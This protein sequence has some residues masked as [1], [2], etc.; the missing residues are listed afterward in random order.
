MR[1]VLAESENYVLWYHISGRVIHHEIRGPLDK[2]ELEH[3]LTVGLEHM[4]RH[5][6]TKWVSDDRQ[7]ST[8]PQDEADWA[9]NCWAPQAIKAGW[10]HWAVL[11]PKGAVSGLQMKR[12]IKT[13]KDF[14]VEVRPFDDSDAAVDWI[15]K[16]A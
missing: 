15:K 12:F 9:Q 10:T 11:N 16:A 14:G 3:L 7:R 5:Q 13:F 4:K 8:V 6:V 1:K 2:G